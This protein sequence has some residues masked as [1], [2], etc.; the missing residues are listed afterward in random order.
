M[1]LENTKCKPLKGGRTV[2]RRGIVEGLAWVMFNQP[3]DMERH[4]DVNKS[5]RHGKAAFTTKYFWFKHTSTC[6]SG[7][8]AEASRTVAFVPSRIVHTLASAA[9]V[10]HGALIY[11]WNN[12]HGT[13]H[14]RS[15]HKASLNK[16][17]FLIIP[18]HLYIRLCIAENGFN[19]RCLITL[20]APP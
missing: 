18:T 19:L 5:F 7:N 6:F 10:I 15:K 20:K 4:C 2:G 3:K 1:A 9:S 13:I 14:R 12:M 11:I 8:K 16:I 17:S